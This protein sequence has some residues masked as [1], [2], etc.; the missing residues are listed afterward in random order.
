MLPLNHSLTFFPSI[1][2]DGVV[3]AHAEFSVE[4]MHRVL[5]IH[6]LNVFCRVP[7]L[8][9]DSGSNIGPVSGV[10][11]DE[12]QSHAYDPTTVEAGESAIL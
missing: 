9:Q 12:G 5:Q 10:S 2:R 6:D 3:V 8:Q 1:V 7:L 11:G 4:N